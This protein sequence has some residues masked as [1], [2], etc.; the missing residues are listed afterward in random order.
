[1]IE[2]CFKCEGSGERLVADTEHM[3]MSPGAPI[4]WKSVTCSRCLGSGAVDY[5]IVKAEP[6]AVTSAVTSSEDSSRG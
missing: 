5:Q 2:K 3:N 6:V 1:M 4:W